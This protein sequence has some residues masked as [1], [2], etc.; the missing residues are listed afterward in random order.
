MQT[1]RCFLATIVGAA[2]ALAVSGI[3]APPASAGTKHSFP[4]VIALP[5]GFQP[6][7]IA[8]GK[9]PYAYL[10]S[11]ADG[12]IY[13]ASLVTGRGEV[14]SQGPGTQSVGLKIDRRDRLFVAGGGAGDGRVVDARTGAALAS[15]QFATG[16]TFV[17]D[18]VLTP[19][20]AFFTDSM[21]PFLYRVALDLPIGFVRVPL[22]GDLVYQAGFNT[23]GIALTPDGTALLVVQSNTGGLFRVNPRTGVTTA[24]DLG[25]E[26][27]V[28]GD[29]LLVIG[30]TLYVVQNQDNQLAVFHLNQRGT[31]GTLVTHKTSPNFDVPTTVAAFGSRL[32]LPNARFGIPS[33]ET[34]TYTVT[35]I[36]R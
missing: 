10:G 11:L 30:R 32:Y 1:R 33:P 2:P 24:V 13:R 7:G 9:A 18:V 26:T 23:N 27:V 34:A 22:T 35:A 21:Q 5:T 31:R 25:G 29:G 36:S 17:N 6:E 4:D 16:A 8:I 15:Y 19:W 12:D 14:I 28:N 3:V 20:G